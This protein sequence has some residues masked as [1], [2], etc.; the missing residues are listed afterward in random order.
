M[1]NLNNTA[2]HE[3]ER[4]DRINAEQTAY[5]RMIEH[6]A[7]VDEEFER[8]QREWNRKHIVRYRQEHKYLAEN[9]VYNL[10]WGE[11]D[12]HTGK[13]PHKPGLYWKIRQAELMEEG[14]RNGYFE[15]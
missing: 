14:R 9:D 4:R 10:L 8:H 12:R 13:R 5:E 1:G 11:L 6:G 2:E 3:C 7:E 15:G